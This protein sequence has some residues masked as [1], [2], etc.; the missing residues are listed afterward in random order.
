LLP[1]LISP[2]D[3][4]LSKIKLSLFLIHNRRR[5]SSSFDLSGRSSVLILIRTRYEGNGGCAFMCVRT[6][7]EA[8][9]AARNDNEER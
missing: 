8:L 3:L 6:C 1:H 9:R 4:L 5:P 7:C 2:T